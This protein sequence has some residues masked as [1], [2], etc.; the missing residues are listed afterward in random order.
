LQIGRFEALSWVAGVPEMPVSLLL[1]M[2][3]FPM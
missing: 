2:R 3:I 1:R